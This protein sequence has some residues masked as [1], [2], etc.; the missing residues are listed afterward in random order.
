MDR[1]NVEAICPLSPMQQTMLLHSLHAKGPDPGFLQLR[2][3]LHGNLDF[4]TFD[5]AWRQVIDRHQAL[6]SSIHW[7]DLDK[8]LQVVLRNVT[9]P[10]TRQ[11]W[12]VG[13]LIEAQPPLQA[14]LEADRNRGFDL[15]AP[16][17]MRLALFQVR[18][19]LHHFVWSCHHLLLDGWSGALVL[20]EVSALYEGLLEG[21]PPNLPTPR[22]YREYINWLQKTDFSEAETFWRALLSDVSA[23]TPLPFDRESEIQITGPAVWNEQKVDLTHTQSEALTAFARRNRVSLSTLFHGVWAVVLRAFSEDDQVVFG[24]TVSGRSSELD[25]IDT[26]VGLFINTLPVRVRVTRDDTFHSVLEQLQQLQGS[27]HPF[28]HVPLPQV[29]RWSGVPAH[30]RLFDSLLVVENYP[31]FTA[32]TGGSKSLVIRNFQGGITSNYPLTLV[33]APGEGLSVHLI[34]DERRF[35]R[36]DVASVLRLLRTILLRVAEDSV[37][38]VSDLVI[39]EVNPRRNGVAAVRN[40][41]EK[42][43]TRKLEEDYVAPRNPIELQLVQIWEDLL[44]VRPIGVRDDFFDVGGHSLNAV[45][46]FDRI[47]SVFG[48]KLPLS[49]LFELSTIERLA[50]VLEGEEKVAAWQALVPMQTLGSGPALFCMHSWDG[51]V[52]LYRDLAR[53]LAPDFPVFGLQTARMDGANP[54]HGSV[55]AIASSYV[56][57]LKSVQTE[58][59]YYLLGICFGAMIAFEMAQQLYGQGQEV[60]GLF[61]VDTKPFTPPRARDS[62]TEGKV[63]RYVKRIARLNRNGALVSEVRSRLVRHFKRTGGAAS[64][65]PVGVEEVDFQTAPNGENEALYKAHVRAWKSYYPR[66]YPGQLTVVRSSEW[67]SRKDKDWHLRKWAALASG[68]IETIIVTGEHSSVLQQPNVELLSTYLRKCIG[69]TAIRHQ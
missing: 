39:E 59:P 30:L 2:C 8:P 49:I 58:G 6:R 42:D 55:E 10:W 63:Q 27:M 56:E 4:D 34:C 1:K 29:Q 41:I 64:E 24:T 11:K 52:L 7:K 17:V 46:L 35:E 54:V 44:K 25:G 66:V 23:P 57:E 28:E 45:H 31:T 36:Q 47:A 22:P 67:A 16:P 61:I 43:L 69:S 53:S 19:D 14:Y 38:K 20:N 48:K 32:R 18:D 60:G 3:T 51:Q 15:S 12:K 37:Q 65:Y 26:M 13:A 21:K 33:V 50:S 5:S 68:G 62:R 9:I 40:Q